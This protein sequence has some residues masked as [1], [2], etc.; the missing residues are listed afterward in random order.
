MSGRPRLQDIASACNVSTATVSRILNG[1][2]SFSVRPDVRRKVRDAAR[3]LGYVPDMAARNLNRRETRIVGVFG[4]P[5]TH[6]STGVN[7]GILDGLGELLHASQY[8]VFYQVTPRWREG[9]SVPFWRFDGAILLQA[10]LP[11]AVV[12]LNRRK[13]PYVC[14]N[15]NVGHP[16]SAVLADDVQG[17]RL[18]VEHLSQL[19]HRRIA[20]ANRLTDYFPHHSVEDRHNTLQSLAGRSGLSLVAGHDAPFTSAVDFVKNARH[21]G[22]T[23]IITYDH[24]IAVAV[25]GAAHELKIAIPREMS[26]LCFNDEFP[27]AELRPAVT[28]VT[29]AGKTMG[30]IA[31]GA[32]I[33]AIRGSRPDG[34]TIIRVPESLVTRASTAQA[35]STR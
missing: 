34:T 21:H 28:A 9:P 5:F 29:V 26:L 25:H 27:V 11:E 22:A 10:P 32:L 7:E 8:D 19:G 16:V 24:R 18:A 23:A 13:V 20:Y 15:E 3:D 2:T 33:Q 17:M 1:D 14:V 31:A 12:E 6:F 35:P 4:S 30:Q